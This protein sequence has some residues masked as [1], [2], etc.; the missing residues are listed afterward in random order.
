MNWSGGAAHNSENLT[1]GRI[2]NH[3]KAAYGPGLSGI[4]APLCRPLNTQAGEDGAQT[5]R[6]PTSNSEFNRPA[7]K[8]DQE[9]TALKRKPFSASPRE[10]VPPKPS[11]DPENRR[12]S[13]ESGGSKHIPYA[14]PR[15]GERSIASV[16]G[17]C[18]SRC[19]SHG[20]AS[21]DPRTAH[22]KKKTK[23]ANRKTRG[24]RF[25]NG[26]VTAFSRRH[27]DD[28]TKKRTGIKELSIS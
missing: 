23:P 26:I 12:R 2:E 28:A 15:W 18:G 25:R 11:G 24:S 3:L 5:P 13:R 4:T 7:M 27:R 19:R 6:W 1:Y 21:T 22:K 17:N 8:F 16:I 14:F 10:N 20:P 9:R